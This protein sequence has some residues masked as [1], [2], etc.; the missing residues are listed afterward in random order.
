MRT[1][2]PFIEM[3]PARPIRPVDISNALLRAGFRIS[4]QIPYGELTEQRLIE[5]AGV[6]IADFLRT[7]GDLDAYMHVMQQRL[8]QELSDALRAALWSDGSR[9]ERLLLASQSY[10]DLCRVRRGAHDWVHTLAQRSQPLSLTR[11]KHSRQLARVLESE[12]CPGWPAAAEAEARLLIAALL[13]TARH[14]AAAGAVDEAARRAV[15]RFIESCTVDSDW[16]RSVARRPPLS[17]SG[18][19]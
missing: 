17:P 10:L 18:D 14:E 6:E 1:A 7:F 15:A 8:M 4:A 13:D 2:T 3:A 11:R 16:P 9:R 19:G 5:A 12:F